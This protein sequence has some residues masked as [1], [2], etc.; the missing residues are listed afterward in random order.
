[1]PFTLS[2][3]VA[4]LP[5]IRRSGAGR[6]PLF[7]SAL[8]AGSFAPDMTYYADTV[9]P[10]AMEFGAVTHSVPGV[11]TVDVLVTAAV[12]ALWLLLREPLVAL[13][14]ATRRGRVYAFVRGRRWDPGAPVLPAAVWFVVSAAIGAGTH[15]VWDAFTHHSRWGTELVPVLSRSVGGHP[16]FQ[17]VQYGSS[18]VAL[19][20][21]VRFVH[22]GL[23]RTVPLPVPASVPV[24]GRTER[25]SAIALLAGCG[26]LGTAHRCA[27]WW[28]SSGGTGS[29]LD[30]IPTACFGAGA[31][32]AVG[33]VLFGAWMRLRAR[34]AALP[35]GGPGAE[36]AP[37]RPA[38][39]DAG[40]T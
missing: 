26:L 16:V 27:R 14:P 15:V 25:R 20:V 6:G 39:E 28:A 30:I 32:L 5:G 23:R 10:G 38:G 33:L 11:F 35:P 31:G 24:L 37:G 19:T 12:V 17:L 18:A 3:A 8:V 1:M 4:V 7:A 34:T 9:I 36:S 2:H 13:L 40:R 22:T 29:P 21:L